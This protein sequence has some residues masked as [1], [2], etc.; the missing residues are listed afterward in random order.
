MGRVLRW[1]SHAAFAVS[2]IVCLAACTL[3]AASFR[4][5]MGVSWDIWR[6]GPALRRTQL[7]VSGFDQ[8]VSFGFIDMEFLDSGLAAKS[9][10]NFPQN[11]TW[12]RDPISLLVQPASPPP[13]GVVHLKR[14]DSRESY[15]LW[16]LTLP[17]WSVALFLVTLLCHRAWTL[18]RRWNKR[19][20][21]CPVCGYDMRATP[22]R[23]PECGTVST[24]QDAD[25]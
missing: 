14:H 21:A 20:G 5:L 7:F 24:Q 17:F 10:R 16:Y 8:R 1:T 22:E 19:P 6:S 13:W 18:P 3:W 15:F 12:S 2:L 11:F 23:C 9:R 4:A 25:V